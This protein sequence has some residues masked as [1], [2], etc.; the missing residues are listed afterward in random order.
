[1]TNTMSLVYGEEMYKIKEADFENLCDML[2]QELLNYFAYAHAME[3]RD[4]HNNNVVALL[5]KWIQYTETNDI[6][7][8]KSFVYAIEANRADF[9]RLLVAYDMLG[10]YTLM[11]YGIGDNVVFSSGQIRDIY[12]FLYGISLTWGMANPENDD[13]HM[14][15]CTTHFKELLHFFEKA[16]NRN[17]NEFMHQKQIQQLSTPSNP[18]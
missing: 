4:K 2:I 15:K 5:A 12:S 10:I 3:I 18:M 16:A 7:T 11:M 9:M 8:V 6:R 1:M 14:E 17:L 13:A